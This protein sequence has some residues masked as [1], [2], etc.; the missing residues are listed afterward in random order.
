ME[1]FD[2]P[3]FDSAREKVRRY[4]EQ[5]KK[6]R[7]TI[8]KPLYACFKCSSSNVF[9]ASKQVRFADEGTSV[10]NECLKCHNKWRDKQSFMVYQ[11]HKNH[12]PALYFSIVKISPLLVLR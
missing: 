1:N 11:N 7:E 10:F 6:P 9:S 5:L 4:M 12:T 3:V 8:D 2:R